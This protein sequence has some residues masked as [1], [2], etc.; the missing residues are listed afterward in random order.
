MVLVD[1]R[2][3]AEH[4]EQRIARAHPMALSRFDPDQLRQQF[5]GKRMIFH[6]KGGKRSAQ[7][8]RRFAKPGESTEHLAG[9][10]DAWIAAGLPTVKPE[11]PPRLPVMRQVLLTAGA[12][13]VLGLALGWFVHPAFLLLSAFVGFGL[14]FSGATGWCGM[15]MLLGKM[16]WNG[17]R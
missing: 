10:I 13:V 17:S 4:Y 14:M 7:A 12:L 15:A 16:P 2:E 11:V 5:A 9:G 3:D 1:V 6:C 8:C